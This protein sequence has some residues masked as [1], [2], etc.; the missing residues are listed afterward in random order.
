MKQFFYV[1]NLSVKILTLSEP[2]YNEIDYLKTVKLNGLSVNK[3][4]I[5][6]FDYFIGVLCF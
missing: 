4:K 2:I 5:E 3:R 6:F 1:L